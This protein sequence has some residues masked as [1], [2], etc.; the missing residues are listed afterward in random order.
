MKRKSSYALSVIGFLALAWNTTACSQT[1]GASAPIVR[2][3]DF[4]NQQGPATLAHDSAEVTIQADV[5]ATDPYL[6]DYRAIIR[7]EGFQSFILDIGK[8][9]EGTTIGVGIGKLTASD[10]TPSILIDSFSGGA[11]CC[12]LLSVV[13]VSAG[14]LKTIELPGVDGEP[15]HKFPADLDGDGSR[16]FVS[17]DDSFLYQ[18]GSYASSYSPPRVFNIYKGALVDVSSEP[19]FRVLWERFAAKTKV[20]CANRADTDRN[21]ACIAYLAA[22][23]RLGRFEQA[24]PL[25]G[26]LAYAGPQAQYPSGCKVALV[27]YVC[28]K[29]QEIEFHSFGPAARWLLKSA[30]YIE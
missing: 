14:R 9:N 12:A 8:L 17:Q 19:G 26:N 23:A 20:A 7:I 28:P 4:D 22:E 29:G 3:F 1:P 18:F 6:A 2:V 10:K 13:T 27:D 5:D 16:D 11:H 30:G 24:F 25:V 15:D 21:G